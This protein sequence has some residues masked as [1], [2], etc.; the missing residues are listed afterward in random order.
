MFIE[1]KLKSLTKI[2]RIFIER[3][4]IS[5]ISDEEYDSI[6]TDETYLVTMVRLKSGK[7]YQIS[8]TAEEFIS[9][10]EKLNP[11]IL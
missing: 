4:E 7:E 8:E 3:N 6:A 9:R 5:E 1:L 10:I 2:K 11:M